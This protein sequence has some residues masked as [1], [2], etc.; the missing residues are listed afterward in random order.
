MV[1]FVLAVVPAIVLAVACAVLGFAGGFCGLLLLF[2][3]LPAAL[4]LPPACYLSGAAATL[5]FAPS[6]FL[7]GPIGRKWVRV[8]GVKSPLAARLVYLCFFAMFAAGVALAVK[9]LLR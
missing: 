9:I 7:R 1:L 2:L 4:A 6:D 3:G 8:A 5:L